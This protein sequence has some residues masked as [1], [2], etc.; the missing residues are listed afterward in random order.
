LLRRLADVDSDL[1]QTVQ[2]SPVWRAKEDLLMTA[3]M[4]KPLV[5]LT[6]V[7]NNT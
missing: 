6:M 4:R 1:G 2:K 3:C 5:I 7:R